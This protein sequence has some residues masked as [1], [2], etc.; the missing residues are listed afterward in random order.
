MC[1]DGFVIEDDVGLVLDDMHVDILAGAP[2]MEQNDISV[3]P[4]KHRITFGDREVFTY[5]GYVSQTTCVVSPPSMSVTENECVD[6]QHETDTEFIHTIHT[7][8]N[9]HI[10]DVSLFL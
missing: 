1:F 10:G 5:G 7:L 4:S 8:C 6:D 3:R 9:V 2:F